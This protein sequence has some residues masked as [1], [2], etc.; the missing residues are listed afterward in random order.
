MDGLSAF[1]LRSSRGGVS[2]TEA[3]PA[4][5]GRVD[6]FPGE[7]REDVPAPGL[8]GHEQPQDER[9]VLLEEED[10]ARLLVVEI[11]AEDAERRLVVTGLVIRFRPAS[12]PSRRFLHEPRDVLIEEGQRLLPDRPDS[13]GPG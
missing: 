4:S 8:T 12:A 7:F 11:L 10:V 3:R 1:G 5:D 13:V 2:V 9:A 6:V